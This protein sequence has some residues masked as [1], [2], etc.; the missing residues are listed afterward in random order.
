MCSIICTA[1]CNFSGGHLLQLLHRA[2]ILVCIQLCCF[3]L[4]S[5]DVCLKNGGGEHD[6]T[7]FFGGLLFNVGVE[8]RGV[9]VLG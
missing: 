6:T 4:V 7:G 1:Y 8:F 3:S 9:R 2:L 5:C